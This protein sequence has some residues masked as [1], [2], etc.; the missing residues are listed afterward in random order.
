[1]NYLGLRRIRHSVH[2][3]GGNGRMG[4]EPRRQ[5][6]YGRT[7]HAYA[8]TTETRFLQVDQVLVNQIF[9][10]IIHRPSTNEIRERLS[11]P[12]CFYTV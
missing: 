10:V 7:H 9:P 8:T 2:E 11:T 4:R 5:N 1:M 12:M 6:Q 3:N